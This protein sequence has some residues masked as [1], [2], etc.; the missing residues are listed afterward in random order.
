MISLAQMKPETGAIEALI[1]FSCQTAWI[2]MMAALP[3]DGE[4]RK[5]EEA[6]KMSD[7]RRHRQAELNHSGHG[8]DLT[9]YR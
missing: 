2:L 7:C 5:A 9:A 6:Q 1:G 8:A 4:E 3:V